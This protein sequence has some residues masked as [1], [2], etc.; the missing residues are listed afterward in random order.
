MNKKIIIKEVDKFTSE[1]NPDKKVSEY[2]IYLA[3]KD[4]SNL[5]NLECYLEIGEENKKL[6]VNELLVEHFFIEGK[7]QLSNRNKIIKEINK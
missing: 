6:R 3:L 4:G 5:K 7:L 1:K 2:L